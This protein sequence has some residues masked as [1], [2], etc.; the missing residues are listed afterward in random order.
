MLPQKSP[1]TQDT[2]RRHIDAHILP[3][4]GGVKLRTLQDEPHRLQS[5]VADML[6]PT[7]R[8]GLTRTTV[9]DIALLAGNMFA[10]AVRWRLMGDNPIKAVDLP[11][12]EQH[13]PKGLDRQTFLRLLD[14]IE[15]APS[16]DDRRY[17]P[18][19]ATLG[20]SGIRPDEAKRLTWGDLNLD[21][22]LPSASVQKSKTYAGVRDVDLVDPLVVILKAH[23]LA[24]VVEGDGANEDRI[25]I[26]ADGRPVDM[27]NFSQ[28]VW[29]RLLRLAGL[30]DTGITPYV[31]RHTYKTLA[32]AAGVPVEVVS[33]SMGHKKVSTTQDIYGM[34][35]DDV[36]ME[37]R[38]R[39]GG[40][41][42]AKR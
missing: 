18:L 6:K 28:R 40:Y 20:Y 22:Y 42:E 16:G 37:A 36:R 39:L 29:P 32:R 5:W 1:K 9:R 33:R 35:P 11:K 41:L 8:G 25:F 7:Y 26:Q 27:H 21:G 24:R 2:Y 15:R 14:A 4:L 12:R 10:H 13:K 23:H 31:L 38:Q 19:V 17:F 30:E 3:A 34:T